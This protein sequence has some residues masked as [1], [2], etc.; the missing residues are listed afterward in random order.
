MTGPI[1]PPDP[2]ALP[3]YD[4]ANKATLVGLLDQLRMTM[5]KNTDD[6]LPATVVSYDRVNNMATIQ[7]A[8]HMVTTTGQL[9][10]RASV[11]SIPVLALGGGGFFISFPLVAGSRGWI[12]ANDRDISLYIQ[13]SA[14]A[15]PNSQRMHK[16]ADG[17]F[18]PD[19]VNGYTLS[20][21]DA[22]NMVI[23]SIDGTTKIALGENLVN[24]YAASG[25]V[26]VNAE[27]IN[28]NGTLVING[29][30]Y[31][32][33]MHIDAGGEGDSGPVAT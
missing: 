3:G 10:G 31:L 20:D 19:I 26:N 18:I 7:P 14:A 9:V 33:H 30:A 13:Q 15:A 23:S 25:V 2:T 8:V 6:M 1:P 24:I 5:L 16:F 28:L 27:T 32:A 22:N 11:A 21:D 29:T 4:Y 17:L 12:K